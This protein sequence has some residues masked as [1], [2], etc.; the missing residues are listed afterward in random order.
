MFHMV[1]WDLVHKFGGEITPKDAYSI[2]MYHNL[3]KVNDAFVVV[4]G[5]KGLQLPIY[6]YDMKLIPLYL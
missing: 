6:M 1:S 4:K 5:M 3:V 2:Y